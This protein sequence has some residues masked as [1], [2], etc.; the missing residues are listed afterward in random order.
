MVTDSRVASIQ[1]QLNLYGFRC[2]HRGEEKGVFFH[3]KFIRGAFDDAVNIRRLKSAHNSS[4]N[5]PEPNSLQGPVKRTR[6]NDSIND[7]ETK[8]STCLTLLGKRFYDEIL[9]EEPGSE[10][11]SGAITDASADSVQSTDEA[12][13]NKVTKT[14][15]KEQLNRATLSAAASAARILASR[16]ARPATEKASAPYRE[17]NC[18]DYVD[19]NW[20]NVKSGFLR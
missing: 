19:D 13:E 17:F 3:P 16:A 12:L 18:I 11:Q 2:A 5:D 7:G 1:R 9:N 6:R 10:S 14:I 4:I 8:I 20:V 15:T